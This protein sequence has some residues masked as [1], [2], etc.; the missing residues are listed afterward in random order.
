MSDFKVGDKVH[1][2]F[3]GVVEEVS[4]I[5]RG[6]EPWRVG[7]GMGNNYRAWPT[8]DKVNLIEPVYEVGNVYVDNDGELFYRVDETDW[9]WRSVPYWDRYGEIYPTRPLRKLVP[10]TA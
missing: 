8:L 2:E 3:D 6:D 9:P 1:V 4:Q 10:E 5:G 7:V